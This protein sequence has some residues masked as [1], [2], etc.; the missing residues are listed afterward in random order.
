MVVVMAVA[1]GRRGVKIK[2]F[3]RK[4]E[5]RGEKVDRMRIG[6]LFRASTTPPSSD[7]LYIFTII[8]LFYP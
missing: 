2:R 4:Q 7:R 3:Y 5:G 1:N 6:V 8:L